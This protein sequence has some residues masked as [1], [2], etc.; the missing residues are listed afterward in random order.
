MIDMDQ[1]NFKS[2][3]AAKFARE[4]QDHPIDWVIMPRAH[5]TAELVR[6]ARNERLDIETLRVTSYGLYP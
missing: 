4:A 5:G 1:R 6:V 2:P 3:V